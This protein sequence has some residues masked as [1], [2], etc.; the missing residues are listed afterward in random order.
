MTRRK[1]ADTG[2]NVTR[3]ESEP[4]SDVLSILVTKRRDQRAA[5]RFF[6][7]VLK[8]QGR[9]PWQLITDKLKTYPAA[10]REV[11]PS[12]EHK[13]ASMRATGQKFRTSTPVNKRGR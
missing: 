6:R 13:P 4:T 1:V 7:K 9:P 12:V 10:H 8:E 5:R 2:F 3:H 11:F